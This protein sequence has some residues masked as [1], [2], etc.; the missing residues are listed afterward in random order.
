GMMLVFDIIQDTPEKRVYEVT[1]GPDTKGT[2][3]VDKKTLIAT[4]EG[5]FSSHFP[6]WFIEKMPIGQ[7][8]NGKSLKHFVY[9]TG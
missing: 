8:K 3:T 2:I 4:S 6:L 7:V 9:G 1:S 5:T